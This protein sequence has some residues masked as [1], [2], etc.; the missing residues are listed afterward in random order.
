MRILR[1]YILKEMAGPFAFCLGIL[2][3]VLVMGNFIKLADLVIN[4]GVE[5][6]DV[7]SLR[8]GQQ[9]RGQICQKWQVAY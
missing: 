6:G 8:A 3:M 9:Q 1:N 5:F 2:T 7:R 4:K